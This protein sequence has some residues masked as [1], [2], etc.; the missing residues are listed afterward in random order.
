M[1]TQEQTKAYERLKDVLPYLYFAQ[2]KGQAQQEAAAG[3]R[4]QVHQAVGEYH[5]A[6]RRRK[7]LIPI[8]ANEIYVKIRLL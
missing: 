2:G 3:H 5:Q 7:A 4:H 8:N 1:R 6:T